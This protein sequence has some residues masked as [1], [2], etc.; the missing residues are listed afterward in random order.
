MDK[1]IID[2]IEKLQKEVKRLGEMDPESKQNF[3]KKIRLEFNYN[4]NH[5]E[6]NTLTYSETELL[7]M[8]D[9]AKGNHTLREYEEMKG[10]D[11]ALKLIAEWASDSERFLSEQWI[12]TLNQVLLVRPYWKE[13]VTPDGQQTRREIRVGDYKQHPNSV[14]LANG[15]L[16][17]Y[18]SPTDTPILMG[19]LIEWYR[20][21]EKKGE[22]HPVSLAAHLHYKF[23]RI[24]PFDDGNGR[25]SRLLMNYVLFRNGFPPVIIKSSDKR[26]YLE[27]LNEADAGNIEAFCDYVGQQLFWSLNLSLKAA[28]KESLDEPGDLDKKIKLLKQ[29]LNIDKAVTVSKSKDVLLKVLTTELEPIFK[30]I[31]DKLGEFDILFKSK[32]DE[33]RSEG[34]PWGT[35]LERSLNK[36]KEHLKGGQINSL[37]YFYRLNDFRKG[38][39]MNVVCYF[40]I[41]FHMNIYEI[42]SDLAKFKISKLYDEPILEDERIQIIEEL[43]MYILEEIE[44]AL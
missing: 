16:F 25:V 26:N 39:Q 10:S 13:A 38:K 15:E 33:L 3:E 12:K 32:S 1:V 19:E 27:A 7:L 17:H 29:K 23:V 11:V 35:T 31:S 42:T 14:R 37:V 8:F 43:G 4:T 9:G 36:I 24:H 20:E 41:S 40:S 21:E 2:Q 18:A 44:K 22:I 34:N 30:G 28:N 5:L 6:G